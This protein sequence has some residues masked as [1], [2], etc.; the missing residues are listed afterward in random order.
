MAFIGAIDVIG[1]GFT[2]QQQRLDIVSENIVN[3]NI[4][5]LVGIRVVRVV[6]QLKVRGILGIVHRAGSSGTWNWSGLD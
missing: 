5:V 3:M 1:S 2:A 4:A 6:L